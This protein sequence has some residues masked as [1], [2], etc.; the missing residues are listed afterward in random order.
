MSKAEKPGRAR[1]TKQAPEQATDQAPGQAT[2]PGDGRQ[3]ARLAVRK[4]YKLYIGGAFPRSESGR[5]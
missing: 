3:P 2:D 1:A 5:S 4:T